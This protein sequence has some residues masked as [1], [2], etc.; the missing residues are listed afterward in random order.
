MVH[1]LDPRVISIATHQSRCISSGLTHVSS[2]V[3][4]IIVTPPGVFTDRTKLCHS[5]AGSTDT[6]ASPHS[7]H[8]QKCDGRW[9]SLFQLLLHEHECFILKRPKTRSRKRLIIR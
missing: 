8:T 6:G 2:L 9:V 4:H 1:L 5:P 3:S 7:L